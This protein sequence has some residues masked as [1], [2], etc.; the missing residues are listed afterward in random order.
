MNRGV[1]TWGIGRRLYPVAV[2]IAVRGATVDDTLDLGAKAKAIIDSNRYMTLATADAVGVPWVSPVYY[3]SHGYDTFYW[4][5]SP[6]VTHS[7]NIA[8]RPQ[9]SIVIFDS[10]QAPGSGLAVYM[11][12]IAEELSGA[13]L[14]RE[15]QFYPG[16]TGPG[17]RRFTSD[18]LQA[19]AP[20]RLYRASISA[21]WM[22]C[23]RTAGMPC[24]NHGISYDH[25]APVALR[26]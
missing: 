11:S 26:D 21:H 4:I 1:H 2:A 22:L 10:Q 17:I 25:R 8:V 9:T 20:Y 23:P 15:V 13:D 6:E 14:E 19:P 24:A 12:A 16:G 18:Q 7:H 5:S 3:A